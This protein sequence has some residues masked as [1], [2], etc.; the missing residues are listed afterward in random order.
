[1]RPLRL[2]SCV[3]LVLGSAFAQ[4]DRSTIT[5]T[6]SDP[7]GAV[8]AN[9]AISAVNQDT[10][11][12]YQ[13]ASTA[14]GNYGINEL[15]VG[16]YQ[17][18]VTVPGFKKYVRQGLDVQAR[19]TYRIDIALEVGNATESVTVQAE[20]P[21]L[22]TESGE[23]SHNVT[24]ANLDALPVLG[25]GSA[26]G[27]G[28]SGIRSPYAVT[29]LV[30]GGIWAGDLNVRINGTPSNTESLRVEG[31]ES[32][33]LTSTGLAAQNQPSVD[34]IQEF[35]IQTSNYSAEFGQAGG[36]VMIA[37]MKSG[38]NQYHGSGYDYFVNEALNATTPFSN[39]KPRARRNDYGFTAGGPVWVPKVY[40]GRDRSFFFF[41]FEQFRETAIVNNIPV[42]VPTLQYRAGDFSR[43][44]TGRQL[45]TDPLNRPI[46]EGTV[47]DASTDHAAPTGQIV[48]DPFP[49]NLVPS[50]RQDAVALK[51]QNLIPLPKGPNANALVN[52]YL[53]A[54]AAIRH[55]DIESTKF[56]QLIGPKQKFSALWWRTNTYSPYSQVLQ[57]DG[58]PAV[59]TNGR[60]N[61]DTVHT[62]RLN[63]DY[64]VTPTVLL[65]VGAGYINQHGPYDY[66]PDKDSFDPAS[67]GLKGVYK[68]LR[69][70]NITG[71][72]TGIPQGITLPFLCTGTGG[73]V[74]LGPGT[75]GGSLNNPAGGGIF[76]FRPTG[77]ASLTWI[78]GNH[79]FKLGGEFLVGNYIYQ[80][81]FPAEGQFTFSPGETSLPYLAPNTTLS[82]GTPGFPYASFL[83]GAVDSG[84]VGAP[85]DQH[86]DQNTFALFIQDS[87]KVTRKL[88]LDYGLRWD[89]F[90]Y[91]REGAGRMPS[92]SP[93][94]PNPSAGNLPGA[95][96]F[97]G[98][99]P[100]RCQCQFAHNYPYAIGP[101]LGVAY[102]IT[103]KSVLRAGFGVVY[104][105]TAAYDN[106]TIVSNNQF[107]SPGNFVPA[108]YLQ[109]GVPIVPKPWPN[110]DPGQYPNIPGQVALSNTTNPPGGAPVALIDPNAGRP[111]RQLQWSIGL[112]REI[113]T[114]L[115]VEA[116]F[117]GNRGA[118]WTANN[119]VA[120][121]ALTPQ[122]LA[123][124]GLDINN[125]ADQTLLRS[126]LNSPTAIAR[127][128][129]T[130]P[131][132][133]FGLNNTVAQSL[134]PYPMFGNIIG[135]YAPLGDTWYDS[136]Q[137]KVNKR[138]SH[139]L[140]FSYSFVW[141]KS[142]TIGAES[143]GAGGGVV[144][145]VFNRPTNK[146][147]SQFDQP[148][149]SYLALSYMLPGLG[150]NKAVSWLVRDW[151]ISTLLQYRSGLPIQ[152]PQASTNLSSYLF[153]NTFMDRKPGVPLFTQDLNCHCF[154]PSRVFVLNPNAW[155]NPP[156]GQYGTAAAYYG[157]YRY[158]RRPTENL[159]VGRTFR[160]KE[161]ASLNIRAEF[162]NVF[163]RAEMNNP[164]ATSATQSQ[165]VD[166]K[167]GKTSGGF[168]YIS[169]GSAFSAPRN[170]MIVAR[171]QF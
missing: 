146:Y 105:K 143:E 3:L 15:P 78:R 167:T 114:N 36:A 50:Y 168:G 80:Q 72:C 139:G 62:I 123:A 1:M 38:T 153:Q 90:N 9:A 149:T 94:T 60:G 110:F 120:Y 21:L 128:F 131:Y 117:V 73:V 49:G 7:A 13:A 108:M 55:T 107:V 96:I 87:W 121:N 63:Y 88:T 59:I 40:N 70:P 109:N 14:T 171:F 68:T 104:A 145:N 137:V 31:Q 33:N 147:I 140:D 71:L 93:T 10:G 115:V 5:G 97:E 48:R 67:I 151:T 18:S 125:P 156:V 126:T 65:H 86:L 6:I 102:Q 127:G 53:P 106:L 161:K 165:V 83:L 24:G 74:T 99:G 164:T 134:R 166:S 103:P 42:T 27:A 64:T 148:F 54:Y 130:P 34:A 101:R 76:S 157:D 29:N 56:D 25:I 122:M 91:L 136:L 133:G 111:P 4:S 75:S 2:V 118:W 16:R 82:G 77:N 152:S 39:T 66:T 8:V 135:M 95:T 12:E 32:T 57:G 47:Y 79:T 37:T 170:G 138:F 113:F 142:L 41:N 98:N 11:I 69:F 51:I 81:D 100:G 28:N 155:V 30:P 116:S 61:Y 89:Y 46:L 169:T 158:Q 58:L 159:A 52:N 45:G 163:N 92:F 160:F 84:N 112:Q 119:L 162:T 141:Q 44:L 144:N 20:A 132:P 150:G 35:A 23:L 19:Q 26:G 17:L 129:S 43:A 154:D 124:H 85:T 22:K